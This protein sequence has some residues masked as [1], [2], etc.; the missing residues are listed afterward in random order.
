VTT[1]WWPGLDEMWWRFFLL[2]MLQCDKVDIAYVST[3]DRSG[4]EVRFDG[5]VGGGR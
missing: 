4:F 1:L 3:E 5:A 2:P